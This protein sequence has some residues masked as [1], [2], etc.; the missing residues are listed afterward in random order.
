VDINIDRVIDLNDWEKGALI[1]YNSWGNDFGRNGM[2]YV[3]YHLLARFGYQGG[4]WNR[5]VHV[6]EVAK[7]YQPILTLRAS[8]KHSC[9]DKIKIMAGVSTNPDATSPAHVMEFPHFNY[10]GGCLPLTDTGFSCA[11][12]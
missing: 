5:S 7:S 2:A 11:T 9:R 12:I 1:V 8:L 6:V 10:Q 4:F 3:P